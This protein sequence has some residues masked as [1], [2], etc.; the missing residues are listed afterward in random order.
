LERRIIIERIEEDGLNPRIPEHAGGD[1]HLNVGL[2]LFSAHDVESTMISDSYHFAKIRTGI[3]IEFPYGYHMMI[4]SRSGLGFNRHI[5]AFPGIIDHSY[6]GEVIIKLYSPTPFSLKSG[7][8]V[9]QG[10]IFSSLDYNILE[11]KVDT[12]TERGTRGFGSTDQK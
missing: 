8:K 6:R 7:D 9:A 1:Q 10:I 2:D 11:G 12:N 3:R 5:Q 4:G